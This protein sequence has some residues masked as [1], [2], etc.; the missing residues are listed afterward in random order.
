MAMAIKR[1]MATSGN[2]TGNVYNKE[3]GRHS[4]AATMAMGMGTAQR[5]QPLALHLERGG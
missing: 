4:T 2:T 3:G 5:T 1:V